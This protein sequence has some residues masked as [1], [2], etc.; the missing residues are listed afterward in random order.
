MKKN[1]LLQ[2]GLVLGL[3]L[4]INYLCIG[5]SESFWA[6]QMS[7]NKE[8][9]V[10]LYKQPRSLHHAPDIVVY[11]QKKG[12][13]AKQYVQQIRLTEDDRVELGYEIQWKNDEEAV[14]NILCETCMHDIRAFSIRLGDSPNLS[15]LSLD[16]LNLLKDRSINAQI[17]EINNRF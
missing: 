5:T 14:L 8:W 9:A 12:S 17:D 4:L 7:H 6:A 2:I 10:M 1:T 15:N 3:I 13:N 11:Q 16:S